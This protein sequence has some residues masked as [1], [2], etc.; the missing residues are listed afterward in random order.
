VRPTK[1]WLRLLRVTWWLQVKIRSRSA[2]DGLLAL[3]WPLFFATTIFLVYRAG[4]QSSGALL[5]AA[6][7]AAV[8]GIWSATSTTATGALQNERQ[9]GTLE[10]LVAAPT[11]L[12]LLIVPVTLSMATV[13]LYSMVTTLAWGR[14]VFGISLHVHS[15]LL[16]VLAVIVVVIAI[17]MFGFLLSIG[18]VRYRSAWAVGAGLEM[19]VWFV[20]GFL[21]PLSA[22]PA[23]VRPISWLLAPTWGM[24]AVRHASLGGSVWPALGAC[25]GLS[26]AYAVAGTWLT[27]RVVDA[28]RTRATLA[29]T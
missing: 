27:S 9:Q 17:G 23:W 19:P 7:G 5:S 18:S 12:P 4:H 1:R 14:I 10:L 29:L 6:V 22:L 15:P 3:L 20:C 28:A 25:V 26:A 8:M 11:P 13:G 21:I 24:T 2:F 16:F